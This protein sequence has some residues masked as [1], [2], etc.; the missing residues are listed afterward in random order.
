MQGYYTLYGMS[1]ELAI[2][3]DLACKNVHERFPFAMVTF[4][5]YQVIVQENK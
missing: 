4:P 5:I 2:S 1:D 3:E